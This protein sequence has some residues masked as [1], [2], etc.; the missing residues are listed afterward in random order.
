MYGRLQG[1]PTRSALRL[2]SVLS[3]AEVE[4]LE[5]SVYW[6]GT[7]HSGSGVMGS[8]DQPLAP[9]T[10]NNTRPPGNPASERSV[11]MLKGELSG[12]PKPLLAPSWGGTA[13]NTS[14]SSTSTLQS[15][16]HHL[17]HG[18]SMNLRPTLDP[19]KTEKAWTPKDLSLTQGGGMILQVEADHAPLSP[20][21]T[22]RQEKAPVVKQEERA[23][24]VVETAAYRKAQKSLRGSPTPPPFL[25]SA[26]GQSSSM[27]PSPRISTLE[28][29]N[30]QQMQSEGEREEVERAFTSS[31]ATIPAVFTLLSTG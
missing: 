3:A 22:L 20:R 12:R 11:G 21:L 5:Q 6:R 10:A 4:E 13:A 9:S 31:L 17:H 15:H 18:S 19:L 25:Q 27:C 8:Q 14:S 23:I 24:N 28:T 7:G 2:S 16:H 29:K 1:P 30:I 26:M